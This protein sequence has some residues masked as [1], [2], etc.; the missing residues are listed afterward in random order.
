MTLPNFMIIGVAKAGTTSL[1][2]YLDQHP[3][4]FMCPIKGSNYFGYEDAL[5]WRWTD[6]G[7]PPLLRHFQVKTHE[8]YEALFAGASDEIAIGEASPQ[9]FRC[10]TAARR[11]HECIPDVKLVASLRNPADRAFSGF[12]MRTRRGEPVKSLYEELTPEASHVKEG[13]YYKRLK[14]YFD[15]FPKHQIKIY[16]FEEFKQDPTQV[17]VDIFDFLGVDTTVE[18]DTS[19]R[20]NPAGVPKHRLLNRLFFDPTLVRTAKSLLPENLQGMV[21]NVRKMNLATPPKFPAD[22]RAK[23]LEH[24]R[25]DILKLEGLLDRDLSIWLEGIDKASQDKVTSVLGEAR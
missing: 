24:Y 7:E 18:P 16:I 11:I 13:F 3:Q 10:P 2:R 8:A 17:V 14:R 22:L 1:F 23:L 9:Y 19:T 6:E 25:D 4:V 21:K 15:S 5:A 12:M 20:Y